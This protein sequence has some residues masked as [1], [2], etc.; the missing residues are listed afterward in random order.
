MMSALRNSAGV[1]VLLVRYARGAGIRA[2][3][4][5]RQ[6]E[7]VYYSNND[8]VLRAT[9]KDHLSIPSPFWTNQGPELRQF[10]FW[11]EL[12]HMKRRHGTAHFPTLA[13][14]VALLRSDLVALARAG[15]VHYLQLCVDSARTFAAAIHDLVVGPVHAEH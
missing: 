13:A 6:D 7:A 5:F 2:L 10:F 15:R 12:S 3:H 9:P 11:W 14:L 1:T 4:L 8:G